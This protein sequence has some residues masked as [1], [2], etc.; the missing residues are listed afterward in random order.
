[1]MSQSIAVIKG[2]GIGPEIMDATLRVLDALECGLNYEFIDAGLAALEKHG[3]LIPQE[4]LDA[5]EKYGIALKGPLTTP[6]GKGF[7]SINVQLRRHFDL[8]ANVR[9]A[10]SF[11]GTRSRYN[12]IDMITVRENTEGAYLSDGQEMI[13]DGNTGISVIKVTRQGSERIVRYAFELAKN[14]GRK[15]V[16]AVHKANIIKTSSGLFLDVAR[17]VAKEYPEIE[18][19]EMIVD[20]ACMQLVMNPHQ[21]DVVVTTNLFGD[22]LS[23]LCAGLVGGLGLAPGANIGEKAAIFEAVH[24]SAPDIAGQKIA[25]PCALLLAAAQ[26]LDHLGMNEKGDAI[27][28]GI[29]AVLETRRDMVTPDMGGTGTTDTFAQALVEH[30][31]A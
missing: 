13:D 4:S 24:G 9:P 25:N 17:E 3:T 16:T 31:T 26:M 5:I 27:R 7:S 28:H 1:M 22:I 2:D 6:I 15:K 11:P 19:Q 8:Y 23:D 14:N 30:L 18:F 12:D 20:N 29:R 10:I 21:F